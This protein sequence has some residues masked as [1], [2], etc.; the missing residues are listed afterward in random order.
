MTQ[1]NSRKK[2]EKKNLTR[3]RMTSN[4]THCERIAI[5]TSR[6]DYRPG[7]ALI[8][9]TESINVTSFQNRLMHRPPTLQQLK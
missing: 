3:I 7:I 1:E 6:N 5:D 9:V 8:V 4:E 2:Q